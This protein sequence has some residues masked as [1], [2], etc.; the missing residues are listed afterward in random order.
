MATSQWIVPAPSWPADD[1]SQI[2]KAAPGQGTHRDAV[3]TIAVAETLRSVTGVII[4]HG[5]QGVETGRRYR[6]APSERFQS[7]P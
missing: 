7:Q 4:G 5:R 6:A 1:T 3:T 2:S